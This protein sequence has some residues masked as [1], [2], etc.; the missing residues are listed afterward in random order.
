MHKSQDYLHIYFN[1]AKMFI[2]YPENL[3][4]IILSTSTSVFKSLSKMGFV[5]VTLQLMK[6]HRFR[7]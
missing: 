4:E 6:Y 1:I 3:Q 5:Y 7:R 2:Q